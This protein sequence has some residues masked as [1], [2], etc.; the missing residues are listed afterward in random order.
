M[1]KQSESVGHAQLVGG[2]ETTLHSH[3]S[4]GGLIDK[5]GMV[6]TGPT[7]EIAVVF[8]TPYSDTNYFIL[9]T[10]VYP[11]DGCYGMVKPGTKTVSGF[12]IMS[13]DDGGKDEPDVDMY[14]VTGPYSNP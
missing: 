14:W 4:G 10:P 3:P 12:T 13:W 9:L 7:S 5:G 11:G 8:N 6:N 2:A 1:V